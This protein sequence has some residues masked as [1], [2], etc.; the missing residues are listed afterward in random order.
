MRTRQVIRQYCHES[1]ESRERNDKKWQ[2]MIRNKFAKSAVVRFARQC[3]VDFGP[4]FKPA[5]KAGTSRNFSHD[6]RFFL[7]FLLHLLVL[8]SLLVILFFSLSLL[9]LQRA[10]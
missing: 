7:I 4:G 5:F 2:E 1:R 3:K 10:V 9:W 6:V 8:Y